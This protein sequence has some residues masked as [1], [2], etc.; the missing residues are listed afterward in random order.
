M[1]IGK[2]IINDLDVRQVVI[3]ANVTI[4]RFFVVGQESIIKID[5]ITQNGTDFLNNIK[6]SIE[7]IKKRRSDL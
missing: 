3:N 5:F 7:S 6:S 2:R 4:N 1:L